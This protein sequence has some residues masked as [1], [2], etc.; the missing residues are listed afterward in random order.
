MVRV[1]ITSISAPHAGHFITFSFSMHEVEVCPGAISLFLPVNQNDRRSGI[2]VDKIWILV[3]D[4]NYI[5]NDNSKG[6]VLESSLAHLAARF[7][8]AVMK[9]IK[10]EFLREGLNITLEQW[11]ILIHVWNYNGI[12][13]N[14]LARKLFKDKTTIARLIASI[15]S[16]G[17]IRRQPSPEDGR[18]KK[19]YLTDQG[20]SVMDRATA[21][22][23]KI[24]D[25][26]V[27]DIDRNEFKICK[28]V[29]SSAHRNLT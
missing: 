8:R 26:L 2:A 29:L 1:S 7:Y 3:V 17:M 25:G 14:D 27:A 12:S 11:P 16:S 13:Q 28:K 9:Q 10:Y 15:E 6:Y 5:M 23:R 18:E 24:D 4:Y 20:K 22:V 19:I 21:I